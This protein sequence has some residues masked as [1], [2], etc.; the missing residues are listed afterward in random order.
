MERV[1]RERRR[2]IKIYSINTED[3]LGILTGKTKISLPE[4]SEITDVMYSFESD[5]FLI[6]VYNSAFPEQERGFYIQPE[7]PEIIKTE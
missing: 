4:G 7:V 2:N 6:K 1:Q 5:A 3:I